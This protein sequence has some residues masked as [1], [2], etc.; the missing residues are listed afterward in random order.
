MKNEIEE[1][2]LTEWTRQECYERANDCDLCLAL[3][4]VFC[5]HLIAS[6]T[7]TAR[8]CC[9]SQKPLPIT[10][11]L[12]FN[13]TRIACWLT[14]KHSWWERRKVTG[15]TLESLRNWGWVTNNRRERSV[16]RLIFTPRGVSGEHTSVY[17]GTGKIFAWI[18]MVRNVSIRYPR[19]IQTLD[20]D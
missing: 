17:C 1:N 3:F 6:R 18:E 16:I 2:S 13:H 11:P 20:D 4:V 12:Q 8:R 5:S 14:R 15:H 7:L 9:N 10:T 19:V